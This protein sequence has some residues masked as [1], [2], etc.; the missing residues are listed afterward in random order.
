[1]VRELLLQDYYRLSIMCPQ[2]RPVEHM[3]GDIRA[4]SSFQGAA[5]GQL[6]DSLGKYMDGGY[7]LS[8]LNKEW[9]LISY[10]KNF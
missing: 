1:M 2:W 9:R 4:W 7:T 8:K 6:S 3:P 5:V 10:G